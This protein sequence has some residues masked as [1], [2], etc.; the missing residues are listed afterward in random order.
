[1][2]KFGKENTFFGFTSFSFCGYGY[3]SLAQNGL[4]PSLAG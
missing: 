2:R 1:M 3:F 4:F